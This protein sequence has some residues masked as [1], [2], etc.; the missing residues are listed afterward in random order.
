MQILTDPDLKVGA[1]T[2][3][4]LH[5]VMLFTRV[6][7]LQFECLG[8]DCSGIL[9]F[10]MPISAV[11]FAFPDNMVILFSLVLGSAWWGLL[12]YGLLKLVRFIVE[13]K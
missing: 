12:G 7:L 2:G 8:G 13:K 1:I 9:W 5:L 6:N 3:I 4:V 11:Y 10:D